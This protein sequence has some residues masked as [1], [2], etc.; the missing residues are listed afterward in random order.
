LIFEDIQFEYYNFFLDFSVP[1][2]D[3][4]WV[5]SPTGVLKVSWLKKISNFE[6]QHETLVNF[7]LPDLNETGSAK[8]TARESQ[9]QN[10]RFGEVYVL[11][12]TDI[13]KNETS[14]PFTV[15]AC[16][17][18]EKKV[19]KLSSFIKCHFL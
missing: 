7:Q 5:V 10:L 13:V 18:P 15:E 17:Y 1:L 2:A 4:E 19:T 11:T 9:V 16:E 8:G 12:L 6:E 3:L 14:D